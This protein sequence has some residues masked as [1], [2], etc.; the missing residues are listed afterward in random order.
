MLNIYQRRQDK[1]DAKSRQ[2]TWEKWEAEKTG[3]KGLAKKVWMGD[4]K[5]GW[6][7]KRMQEERDAAAEGKAFSDVIIDQVK[8]VW[9]VP[10]DEDEDDS[11]KK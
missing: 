4:E 3:V 10:K 6:K 8:E 11:G 9:G 2:E 7:E 1:G 5:L